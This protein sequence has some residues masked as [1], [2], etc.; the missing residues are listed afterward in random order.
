QSL[1][2]VDPS[3]SIPYWEYTMDEYL[4][5]K[6]P[7]AVARNSPIFGDDWFG[8]MSPN[9]ALHTVT[10]GRWA[11]TS[12]ATGA[13]EHVHNS[14]GLL[15]A[16]WNTDPTPYVTRHDMVDGAVFFNFVSC[17][18]Y[19]SCFAATSLSVMNECLNGGTHGPVHII[20][21]GSWGAPDE[22]F[23]RVQ[24]F[25][26]IHLLVSKALWRRGYLRYPESCAADDDDSGE[27]GCKTSCPAAL[28]AA[29]NLTAYDVLLDTQAL[30]WSAR[31]SFG[32]IYY[33]SVT[34][35]YRVAGIEL[36]DDATDAFWERMLAAL[37]NAGHVGEM[38]T[39]SA[40]YDPIFWILHP[41]AERLLGARRLLG[42]DSAFDETWGY[43]HKAWVAGDM[44]VVCDWDD[45]RE[46]TDLPKCTQATCGGHSEDDVLPFLFSL[47]G[48]TGVKLTNAELL[49]LTVPTNDAL[50]YMYADYDWD[51]CGAQGIDLPFH[52]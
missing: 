49:A 16:P 17:S 7:T 37:C 13:W 24:G 48:E 28:L 43:T 26:S 9:N 27:E 31:Y 32:H 39:P 21:G 8:E 52:L 6:S 19:H 1:Q 25:S 47:G 22:A 46:F 40:P 29:N 5:G 33:D 15:R 18:T 36:D 20:V 44:G 11:Y 34:D 45:V 14:H 2:L 30:F 41:A 35:L 50:P 38:Y 23:M 12:V 4:Y 51:W 42:R 10:R 3:V